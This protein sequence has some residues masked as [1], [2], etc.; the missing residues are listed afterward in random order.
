MNHPQLKHELPE[1]KFLSERISHSKLGLRILG[2]FDNTHFK[3]IAA[4][5]S[6]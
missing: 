1:L 5:S 6:G 4:G 2:G 3:L